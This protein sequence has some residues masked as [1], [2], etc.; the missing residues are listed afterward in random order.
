MIFSRISCILDSF[1]LFKVHEVGSVIIGD[2]TYKITTKWAIFRQLTLH[3]IHAFPSIWLVT[4]S[5]YG[6]SVML[7][8]FAVVSVAISHFS[9]I[10]NV[11]SAHWVAIYI[12]ERGIGIYYDPLGLQPLF[13]E[14]EVYIYKHCAEWFWN[15]KTVQTLAGY[16][17]VNFVFSFCIL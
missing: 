6:R 12:N 7:A 16:A 9:R 5:L 13:A 4:A 1:K 15:S 17:W 2:N 3:V 14:L 11:P 8:K 10:G